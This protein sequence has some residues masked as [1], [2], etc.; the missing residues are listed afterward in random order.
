MKRNGMLS[1]SLCAVALLLGATTGRAER[2][3]AEA[4][5]QRSLDELQ[6]WIGGGAK[7]EGW[8]KFL[9]TD[10]LTAELAKGEQA[11]KQAVGE[12]LAQYESGKPGLDRPRFQ[13]VR[14][15]LVAWNAQ[16]QQPV[17]QELAQA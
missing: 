3:L 14:E 5:V 9:K 2:P 13:A 4:Q 8:A 11:N 15:A 1:W 10:L 17:P 16:L 12:V 7:G 6:T